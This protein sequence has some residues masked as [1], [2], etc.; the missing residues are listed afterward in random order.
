MDILE[1]ALQKKEEYLEIDSPPILRNPSQL[2]KWRYQQY[3][4]QED[5][6]LEYS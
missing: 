3:S 1:E 4:E 2:R 6:P 5:Y